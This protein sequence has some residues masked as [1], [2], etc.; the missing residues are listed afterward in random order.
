M[1]KCQVKLPDEL[2]RKISR[3]GS[4]TDE[5]VGKAL[6]AG[7]KATLP[8][9]QRSL[10]DSIGSNLR[11]HNGKSRSTGELEN[12]LGVSPVR[13]D[14]RGNANVKIGFHEPRR[15]K[16]SYYEITNAMIAN[17]MEYGKHGQPAK[18]FLKPAIKASRNA[19]KAAVIST[20]EKEMEKL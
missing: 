19:C 17:V 6:T 12:A 1:A 2:I 8:Y 14:S 18:P 20:L 7:A 13:I 16:S 4:R 11:S 3:L 5:V 10:H 9:V 15:N